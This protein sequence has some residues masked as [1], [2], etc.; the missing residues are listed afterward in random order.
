MRNSG[1]QG[2]PVQ[3]TSVF[4]IRLMFWVSI[5]SCYADLRKLRFK[6]IP[7]MPQKHI[8]YIKNML[9]GSL[10]N[11]QADVLTHDSWSPEAA[12]LDTIMIIPLWNL[13]G[14]SAALLPR[15][16]S[17]FREIGKVKPW[18]SRI[19]DFTRSF[20]KTSVHLANRGP[21]WV[22]FQPYPRIWRT[23]KPASVVPLSGTKTNCVS[24]MFTILRI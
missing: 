9:S 13:T 8:F 14:I 12:K 4:R 18:I 16:L 24:S 17:N 20:G 10:F 11:K 19:R 23:M 6:D 3:N 5:Y 1:S 7:L 15:C 22:I 2:I 21:G